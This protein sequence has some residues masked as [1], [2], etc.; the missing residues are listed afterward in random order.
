M[1]YFVFSFVLQQKIHMDFLQQ[2]CDVSLVILNI[3][4]RAIIFLDTIPVIQFSN[5]TK[6]FALKYERLATPRVE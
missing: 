5:F 6:F 4:K 1:Q 3:L 2:M